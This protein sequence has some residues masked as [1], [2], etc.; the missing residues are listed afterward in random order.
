MR[1]LQCW[2]NAQIK[3]Q[4]TLDN[5]IYVN[6]CLQPLRSLFEKNA[7][8][9]GVIVAVIILPVVLCFVFI[10]LNIFLLFKN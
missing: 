10:I 7:I 4:T 6:G 3:E 1:S 8:R 5:D 9:L 2:Q